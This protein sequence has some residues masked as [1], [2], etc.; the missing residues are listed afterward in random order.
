LNAVAAPIHAVSASF[1]PARGQVDKKAPV[2]PLITSNVSVGVTK[3]P[4]TY[5]LLERFFN[6]KS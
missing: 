6:P 4:F 5:T 3:L 1:A 2:A